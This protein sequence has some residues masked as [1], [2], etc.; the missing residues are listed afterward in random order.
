M[1]DLIV[2]IGEKI[3]NY[4]E[5][6]DGVV[7]DALG[8]LGDASKAI[9]I[10][11]KCSKMCNSIKFNNF[12]RGLSID[13]VTKTQLDTLYKYIDSSDKAE[14]I[15]DVF[16]KIYMANSKISCCLL[17]LVVNDIVNN[18]REFTQM[19]I[20]LCNVLQDLTDFDLYN[21]WD[22]YTEI[23][24]KNSGYVLTEEDINRGIANSKRE[25]C[26]ENM[27]LTLNNLE[28]CSLIARSFSNN[29]KIEENGDA[30]YIEGEYNHRFL[31][32]QS[33]L[34]L[35]EYMKKVKPLFIST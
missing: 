1:G 26:F 9:G 17:G 31:I 5:I 13:T 2:K 21:M 23:N 7:G 15:A 27:Y 22:I 18:N 29:F 33:S 8:I 20:L 34:H 24:V 28:K 6:K 16:K 19:D 4:I 25:N 3:D 14:Y 10:L 12:L 30:L 35:F 11:K 32:R